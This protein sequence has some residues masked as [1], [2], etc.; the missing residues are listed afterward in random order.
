[1]KLEAIFKAAGHTVSMNAE[2]PRRGAFVVSCSGAKSPLLELLNLT[3][4]FPKLK[5]LDIEAEGERC[6]AKISKL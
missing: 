3:R 6:I 5:A 4:P 1:V 2:K